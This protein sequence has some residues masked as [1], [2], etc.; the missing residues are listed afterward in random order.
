MARLHAAKTLECL[1]HDVVLVRGTS[2]Q[3]THADRDRRRSGHARRHFDPGV[4]QRNSVGDPAVRAANSRYRS[5]KG[6]ARPT[7]TLAFLDFL[8]VHCG[9]ACSGIDRSKLTFEILVKRIKATRAQALP[10]RRSSTQAVGNGMASPLRD[11]GCGTC[12]GAVIVCVLHCL[13]GSIGTGVGRTNDQSQ[14]GRRIWEVPG[15][16]LLERNNSRTPILGQVL[17]TG[18]TAGRSIGLNDEES[19]SNSTNKANVVAPGDDVSNLW[20]GAILNLRLNPIAWG[21]GG[22]P[23]EDGRLIH[24]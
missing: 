10:I 17:R 4:R 5:A 20:I 19:R 11:D 24:R 21:D 9:T 16:D 13:V 15:E 18:R 7:I 6:A 23:S 14:V 22:V 8:G 2:G 3:R 12:W 1:A